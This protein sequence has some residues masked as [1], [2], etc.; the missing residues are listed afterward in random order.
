MRILIFVS[1]TKPAIKLYLA[2]HIDTLFFSGQSSGRQ[3]TFERV[4]FW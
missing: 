3:N 1:L 4:P 2:L